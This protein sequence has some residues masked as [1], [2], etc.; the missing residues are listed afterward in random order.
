MFAM[1]KTLLLLSIVALNA[2]S[3]LALS[4][5]G[6]TLEERNT[7]GH[8]NGHRDAVAVEKAQRCKFSVQAALNVLHR[9]IP[10]SIE[11]AALPGDPY[12]TAYAKGYTEGQAE[13]LKTQT[14]CGN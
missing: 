13:A 5:A 12:L 6:E 3:A 10:G 8:A 9:G 4:P 1:K 14:A 7:R 11:R 2:T